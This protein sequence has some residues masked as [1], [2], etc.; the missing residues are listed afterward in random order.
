MAEE[1]YQTTSCH[2]PALGVSLSRL[3]NLAVVFRI[4]R[5]LKCEL[6]FLPSSVR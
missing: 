1:C 3:I 5:Y 4:L 2:H 6:Y